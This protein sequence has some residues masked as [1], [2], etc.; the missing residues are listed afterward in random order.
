MSK[1]SPHLEAHIL[2]YV[3]GLMLGAILVIGATLRF[4]HIWNN[5]FS[6]DEGILGNVA[7]N[8]LQTGLPT[9]NFPGQVLFYDHPPLWWLA[10]AL[11]FSLFGLNKF[12]LRLPA[13]S[14]GI[15]L[16]L[17]VYLLVRELLFRQDRKG[18]FGALTAALLVAMNQ[19]FI[20]LARTSHVEVGVQL[21][22]MLSLYFMFV[23]FRKRSAW[24]HCL[25]GFTTFITFSI[26]YSGFFFVILVLI[27]M[28]GQ[29]FVERKVKP[30]VFW[31]IGFGGAALVMSVGLFWLYSEQYFT[32]FLKVSLFLPIV[33]VLSPEAVSAAWR[34]TD[35]Q[36]YLDRLYGWYHPIPLLFLLSLLIVIAE[37]FWRIKQRT[38][39][40]HWPDV[41]IIFCGLPLVWILFLTVYSAASRSI[42]YSS[43]AVPLFT[44]FIGFQI[45]RIA[46]LLQKKV[47]TPAIK[48]ENS[49]MPRTR[50]YLKCYGPGVLL[51]LFLWFL[52]SSYQFAESMYEKEKAKNY[53]P[54]DPAEVVGHFLTSRFPLEN[55]F[56]SSTHGPQ[57]AL[58]SGWRY[59]L[60]Y[61]VRELKQFQD[62]LKLAR[63]YVQ[64][65]TLKYLKKPQEV[66]QYLTSEY[67]AGLIYKHIYY[68]YRE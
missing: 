13:L 12:S 5:Q 32:T 46:T 65:G 33:H 56:V 47:N 61:D 66:E 16:V 39:T 54:T 45:Q 44:V 1:V 18:Y 9:R 27:T 51:M 4:K 58:I 10:K 38:L 8:W 52:H 2:K 20:H 25:A 43:L 63:I 55:T 6:Y 40:W 42:P 41:Q 28:L 48:R 62:K 57:I 21:A 17:V 24:F 59:D 22:G 15:L 35:L 67:T 68:Y 53:T 19:V 14:C 30:G 60:A 11:S 50:F 49:V 34:I 26:K 36:E 7:L 64:Y 3:P 37:I 29:M 23:A 31:L